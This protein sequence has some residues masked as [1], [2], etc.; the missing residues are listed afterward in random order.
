[1]SD[2]AGAPRAAVPVPLM[3]TKVDIA[4]LRER[5]WDQASEVPPPPLEYVSDTAPEPPNLDEIS[6]Q[7]GPSLL[8]LRASLLAAV[9]AGDTDTAGELFNTLPIDLRRPV[10]ILGS[11]TYLPASTLT[12]RWHRCP[13]R[14][15]H[16]DDCGGVRRHP[17]RWK[18]S[19]IPGAP[20]SAQPCR[21]PHPG[22]RR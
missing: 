18:P 4:H 15:G 14:P 7:G 1:M 13:S 9:E 16:R 11:C 17:P 3:P 12:D 6:T 10:K 8:R 22:C 21:R 20:I 19:A 2:I 5:F